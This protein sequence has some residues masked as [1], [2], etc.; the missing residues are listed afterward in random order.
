MNVYSTLYSSE[1][2]FTF[3]WEFVHHVS[4]NRERLSVSSSQ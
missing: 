3:A 2:F 1:D 4:N